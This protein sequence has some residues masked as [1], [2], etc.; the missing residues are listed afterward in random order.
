MQDAVDAEA[1]AQVV[2]GRFDVDVGRPFLHRLQNDQVDELDDGRFLDD[3]SQRGEILTVVERV[4]H[5][6]LGNVVDL[7]V[8][9]AAF[10]EQLA[11]LAGADQHSGERLAQQCPQIIDGAQ[12]TRIHHAHHQTAA[13]AT[14]RHS[15]VPAADVLGQH[16][17][18]CRITPLWL[19]GAGPDSSGHRGVHRPC[20]SASSI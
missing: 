7:L 12:V 2:F 13:L 15:L 8:Q 19:D 17:R 3:G 18:Q 6:D 4:I 9:L 5:H 14:Q 1:N 16:G 10:I 11:E 20:V